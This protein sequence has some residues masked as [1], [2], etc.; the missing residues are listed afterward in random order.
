MKLP[1]LDELYH[2]NENRPH[3]DDLGARL[4]YL[5][6]A[7]KHI[8]A[9]AN[10]GAKTER[11]REASEEAL[12]W[13]KPYETAFALADKVRVPPPIT[14][15]DPIEECQK[16]THKLESAREALRAIVKNSTCCVALEIA[17]DE[18]RLA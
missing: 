3:A 2:D 8:M 10:N 4:E 15:A 11:I 12:G 9:L 7:M 18:L 16:V 1:T 14:P 5:E 13:R 17:S 6:L